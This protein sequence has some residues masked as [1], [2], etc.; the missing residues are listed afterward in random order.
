VP[1]NHQRVRGILP[2]VNI[3]R[4]SS[5]SVVR[6]GTGNKDPAEENGRC[7]ECLTFANGRRVS[8]HECSLSGISL[9]RISQKEF[10][11]EGKPKRE[12]IIKINGHSVYHYYKFYY[13]LSSKD[14][15]IIQLSTKIN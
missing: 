8:N 13:Y 2:R 11:K 5:S 6:C 1:L 10:E 7:R 15:L 9:R 14:Y 3:G 12:E 4:E